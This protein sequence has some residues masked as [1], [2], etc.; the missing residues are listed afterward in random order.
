[1]IKIAAMNENLNLADYLDELR[2]FLEEEPDLLLNLAEAILVLARESDAPQLQD[3]DE[4]TGPRE[5]WMIYFKQLG[6]IIKILNEHSIKEDR[7]IGVLKKVL[8]LII[9]Q[10]EKRFNLAKPLFFDVMKEIYKEGEPFE[11]FISSDILITTFLEGFF[12]APRQSILIVLINKIYAK[13]ESDPKNFQTYGT[14]FFAQIKA[15]LIYMRRTLSV[16]A[17]PK[18][19]DH[20]M[21]STSDSDS[22]LEENFEKDNVTPPCT[23]VSSEK[24]IGFKNM[25][26]MIYAF[27]YKIII[28]E[29]NIDFSIY[30]KD[31][32]PV[33]INNFRES[34]MK[35]VTHF[36]ITCSIL[37]IILNLIIV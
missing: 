25:L 6:E 21:S 22:A 26:K 18:L 3:F 29:P 32:D 9:D 12:Y 1:M 14:T 27:I 24:L 34:F 35:Q 28:G 7:F 15:F 33:Q 13:I 37:P 16:A 36:K 11:R 10:N 20:Q 17:P 8:C 23:I 30:F 5:P 2:P 31:S 19:A 4:F